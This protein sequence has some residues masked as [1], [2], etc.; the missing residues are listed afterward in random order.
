MTT[1]RH[2]G[3]DGTVIGEDRDAR[4]VLDDA[5]TGRGALVVGPLGSGK[6]H[7]VRAVV[8]LMRDAGLDPLVLRAAAPLA[9][10][11]QGVLDDEGVARL[12]AASPAAPLVV[13]VDDAED[14]DDTTVDRLVRGLARGSV[15]LVLAIAP[16]RDGEPAHAVAVRARLVD[17][18]LA[19]RLV[20]H[21]LREPERADADAL[22]D[23]FGGGHPL[24]R[25]TRRILVARA[26]G[27]RTVLRE[28]VAEAVRRDRAGGDP[29]ELPLDLVEVP[30]LRDALTAE[31]GTFGP[32][33]REALVVLRHLPG[34]PYSEACLVLGAERVDG[35]VT[36]RL[37][38]VDDGPRRGLYVRRLTALVVEQQ[39]DDA[40]VEGVLAGVERYVLER[41]T[42]PVSDVLASFVV[43]R[44]SVRSPDEGWNAAHPS[45]WAR[46]VVGAARYA[47]STGR[48]ERSLAWTTMPGVPAAAPEVLLERTVALLALRE[49][50]RARA[51]LERVEPER[52]GPTSLL[53]Y[54]RCW[55]DLV[56]WVPPDARVE[57]PTFPEQVRGVARA[58]LVL[59]RAERA[60]LTLDWD[61]ALIAARHALDGAAHPRTAVRAA[62]LATFA[63]VV[64]GAHPEAERL[65][66]ETRA[67]LR[68]PVGGRTV[69]LDDELW[70][71]CTLAAA[72][73]LGGHRPD[74]LEDWVVACT[75]AA[76]VR[77]GPAEVGLVNVAWACLAFDRGDGAAVVEELA[78]AASR[79]PA[80]RAGVL[81]ALLVCALGSSRAALGD[82]TGARRA[83]ATVPAEHR[84]F[85]LVDMAARVV[86]AWPAA[87]DAMS[88]DLTPVRAAVAAAPR[89]ERIVQ[90]LT[91]TGGR[92]G[93][94]PDADGGASVPGRVDAVLSDRELEVALLVGQGLTN[95]EVADRLVL[96]VRTVESHVYHACRKLGIPSRRELARVVVTTGVGRR[97]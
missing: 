60:A 79:V 78:A 25:A 96:S 67:L 56:R 16:R 9:S 55:T 24:D 94:A 10:L 69:G 27:S 39:L 2:D 48:H 72:A 37:A 61:R 80:G 88:V 93:I 11:P 70:A 4:A 63:A 92:V 5:T 26:R 76:G 7:L 75:L 77:G 95:R 17:L 83:L 29:L 32:G 53:R 52:L 42:G 59:L 3:H 28:L 68:D 1:A 13:V 87:H 45:T 51:E 40:A 66:R 14:L 97:G 62:G 49:D 84:A 33:V 64:L 91:V 30:G 20:R 47:N 57:V 90:R 34:L 81:R 15:H 73:A 19:H 58:E 38:M 50:A 36:R 44:A 54:V 22:V 85:P 86:E 89:L 6:T 65:A 43:A 18:W 21:D 82:D 23:A 41:A 8:A 35:L 12:D 74:D 31:A 71:L 46:L